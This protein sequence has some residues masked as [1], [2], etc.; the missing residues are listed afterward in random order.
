[1]CPYR[2]AKYGSL[3]IVRREER[4]NRSIY[5][6]WFFIAWIVLNKPYC[7]RYVF[8]AIENYLSGFSLVNLGRMV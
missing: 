1:M 7:R 8:Q 4:S 6:S 2:I 3:K 5:F